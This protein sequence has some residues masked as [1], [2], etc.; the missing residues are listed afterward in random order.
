MVSK[1]G[2]VTNIRLPILL[3]GVNVRNFLN[4]VKLARD[5][6][7]RRSILVDHGRPFE[8]KR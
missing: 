6:R 3:M 1:N 2:F 8:M 7:T 5:G 4:F